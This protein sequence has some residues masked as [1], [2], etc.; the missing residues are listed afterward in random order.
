MVDCKSVYCRIQQLEKDLYYYKTTSR[1]LK[2]RLREASSSQD[3]QT[4]PARPVNGRSPTGK[5]SVRRTRKQLRQ[6]R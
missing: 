2:R 5:S 1:E 6:L 3:S 4:E